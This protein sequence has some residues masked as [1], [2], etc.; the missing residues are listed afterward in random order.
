MLVENDP[1]RLE[2]VLW[3]AFG[4][5]Y[6]RSLL[7]ARTR[8]GI[9]MARNPEYLNIEKT[10]AM[11]EVAKDVL[12]RTDAR[13]IRNATR[14]G[15]HWEKHDA[16]RKEL[17]DFIDSEMP[18]SYSDRVRFEENRFAPVRPNRG[19]IAN[20]ANASGGKAFF[21]KG[22]SF[23]WS[24]MNLD[25]II[26][27]PGV[28]YRVRIRLR[29][30]R[31]HGRKGTV[32][33]SDSL[34]IRKGPSTGYEVA[35]YL[36]NGDRVEILE[37][38]IVGSMVWG[39]I[40]KG[41]ISLSYVVLDKA[42]PETKPETKPEPKPET[43]PEPQPETKPQ[44]PEE[45]PAEP[46]KVIAT[47]TVKVNDFLRIRSG[48]GTSY[49]LVDYLTRGARVEILEMKQSESMTWG[50][51]ERGW[52]SLDYVV[53]D[54]T[55]EQ[56]PATVIT[57]TVKVNDFLRIRTGAGT[58][59]AIA[60]YLQNGVKVQITEQKTVGLTKWGKIEKGW[61]SLDYVVLDTTSAAPE[62]QPEEKPATTIK[63][64]TADCLR[65]RSNAGTSYSIVGYLY[66]GAKVEILETKSVNGTQWGKTAKGWISM[67][68]V[69]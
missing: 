9:L 21:R 52:I 20:D 41:W 27:D 62:S 29:V 6:T 37:Q 53:L 68:Y 49:S 16:V 59:Y 24:E 25:G 66:E 47:G 39:R 2:N 35:G 44:E 43:K 65:I 10:I 58:S 51:I 50:K 64:V 12:K 48:P 22:D 56:Q 4:N 11:K 32:K 57:G 23:G 5:D 31:E 30:E 40:S 13:R 63:T 45:K 38:K 36:K 54:K 14:I 28:E 8:S 26:F 60:G 15:E 46:Q 19:G 67:D 18:S 3:G 61:I 1:V 42:E 69:K 7:Y 33:V 34:R 17:Q 55:A